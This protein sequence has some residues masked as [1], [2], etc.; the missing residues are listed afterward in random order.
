MDFLEEILLKSRF[1][2]GDQPTEAD[3]RLFPTL[4]RFDHVYHGHFKCNRKRLV[5]YHNLWAY[6]RDL[7]QWPGIAETTNLDHARWHYHKSH[8]TVNPHLI[9]PVGP[10]I[11]FNEPHNRG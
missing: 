3:W 11:D 1:L 7:Y 5:D 10:D 6:T 9:L 2:V 4:Y 8:E